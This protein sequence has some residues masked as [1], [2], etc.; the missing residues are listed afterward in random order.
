MTDLQIKAVDLY[1]FID[2]WT[3]CLSSIPML[4]NEEPADRSSDIF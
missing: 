1:R 3:S 2:S 4:S